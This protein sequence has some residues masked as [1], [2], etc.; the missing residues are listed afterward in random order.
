[1]PTLLGNPNLDQPGRQAEELV[2][3]ARS[4]DTQALERLSSVSHEVTLA[5]AQLAIAR[6]FAMPS[7]P[8]YSS[9]RRA[10]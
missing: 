8:A 5:A 3:P 1:M 10:R 4:G 7:W 2:R 6:D 9:G